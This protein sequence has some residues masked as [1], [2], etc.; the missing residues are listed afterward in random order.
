[1]LHTMEQPAKRSPYPSE[2]SFAGLLASLTAPERNE[3]DPAA[4]W[5]DDQLADDLVTLSGSQGR[6]ARTAQ[7]TDASQA[8]VIN[9][10]DGARWNG[11]IAGEGGASTYRSLRKA[12][13]T[14]R[15]SDAESKRL[16]QR[17]TE[18][19]LT[20]SAYVRSCAL[21]VDALRVQVK[22]ALAEIRTT[23]DKVSAT[24]PARRPWLEWMGRIRKSK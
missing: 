1:M 11:T 7:G 10:L 17:A 21:E 5:G 16:R 12:S 19:G 18:A 20:V 2:Q 22:Q 4:D 8:S 6:Q 9:D 15:L 14:I 24:A 13:V 3:P 23:A